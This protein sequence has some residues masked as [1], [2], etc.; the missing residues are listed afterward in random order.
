[1]KSRLIRNHAALALILALLSSISPMPAQPQLADPFA[2][3]G[4]QLSLVDT[5]PDLQSSDAHKPPRSKSCSTMQVRLIR[6]GLASASFRSAVSDESGQLAYGIMNDHNGYTYLRNT[7]VIP[8]AD[9]N[10]I[11]IFVQVLHPKGSNRTVI[12][13]KILHPP[14]HKDGQTYSQFTRQLD[15][16]PGNQTNVELAWGFY[17]RYPAEWVSGEWRFQL[18]DRNCL[19]FEKRIQTI[20]P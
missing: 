11:Y 18:W 16:K 9:G 1:M 4:I 8:I 12:T 7:N 5:Q 10:W 17:K 20:V 19:L 3:P 13:E 2:L 15:L 14:M 6:A